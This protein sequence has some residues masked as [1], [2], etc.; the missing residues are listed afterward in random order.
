MT[1]CDGSRRELLVKASRFAHHLETGWGSL[2]DAAMDTDQSLI[3]VFGASR[4]DV[5][6]PIQALRARFPRSTIVGCSTA[7]EIH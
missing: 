4:I 5:T 2:P 6:A 7:G 3:V 1:L